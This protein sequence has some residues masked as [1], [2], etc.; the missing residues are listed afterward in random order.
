LKAFFYV[1]IVFGGGSAWA[2]G[3]D[4]SQPCDTSDTSTPCDSGDTDTSDTDTTETDTDTADTDTSDTDTADTDTSTEPC[5]TSDTAIPCD[6]GDSADTSD[7]GD[8][9][10][11]EDTVSA[12]ELA[13]ELGGC[14]CDSS[15]L[16]FSAAAMVLMLGVLTTRR[17]EGFAREISP[18]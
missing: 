12:A 2:T 18:S 9:G 6:S 17:R 7:S 4:T 8:T 14:G 1:L 5:D 10:T 13:G 16:P 15:N 3:H 11:D